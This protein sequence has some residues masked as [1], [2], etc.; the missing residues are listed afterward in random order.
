MGVT[1]S[2]KLNNIAANRYFHFSLYIVFC[3]ER[4]F[5]ML[6]CAFSLYF[7]AFLCFFLLICFV[8]FVCFPLP[9]VFMYPVEIKLMQF[10]AFKYHLSTKGSS[11]FISPKEQRKT[12][13]KVVRLM[14]NSNMGLVKLIQQL[15]VINKSRS[16][17]MQ[18]QS[19]LRD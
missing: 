3:I 7:S 2:L 14:E 19:R 15:G 6:Y 18:Y 1:F 10:S 8:L 13:I 5:V 17:S 11:E 9:T 16:G 12:L 4:I